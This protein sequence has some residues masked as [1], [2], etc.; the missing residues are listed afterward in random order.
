MRRTPA[1][2]C[3]SRS[4]QPPS[5]T[6]VAVKE[7]VARR[8]PTVPGTAA[9]PAAGAVTPPAMAEAA[10]VA[11]GLRVRPASALR[12]W[13][14]GGDALPGCDPDAR[15]GR[16]PFARHQKGYHRDHMIVG[17]TLHPTRHAM[18]SVR[19]RNFIQMGGGTKRYITAHVRTSHKSSAENSSSESV[20]LPALYLVA[21]ISRTRRA[22]ST[23]PVSRNAEH[24]S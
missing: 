21:T 20:A 11:A 24:A 12:Q 13:L 10:A 16:R 18:F 3:V 22:S 23:M 4:V 19:A 15:G 2:H 5:C 1:A 17:A 6:V 14:R 8:P 9:P 7:H